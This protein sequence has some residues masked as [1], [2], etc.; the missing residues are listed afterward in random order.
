M[1]VFLQHKTNL[2]MACVSCLLGMV[3]VSAR[4]ILFL[5]KGEVMPRRFTITEKWSDSWFRRLSVEGKVLFSYL[6]DVCDVAGFWEIDLELATFNTGISK[7][8]IPAVFKQLSK[9][10]IEND[11]FIFLQNFLHHQGNFPLKVNNNAHKGILKAFLAHG[12]FGETMLAEVGGCKGLNEID[13]GVVRTPSKGKGKSK[14]K[15]SVLEGGVG[16]TADTSIPPE[17]NL[18]MYIPDYYTAAKSTNEIDKNICRLWNTYKDEGVCPYSKVKFQT[19]YRNASICFQ[20]GYTHEEL[21]KKLVDWRKNSGSADAGPW[22]IW[23]AELAAAKK[24]E[25]G[26]YLYSKSG[27]TIYYADIRLDIS[28]QFENGKTKEEIRQYLDDKYFMESYD[29]DPLLE[30]A[31]QKVKP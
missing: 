7:S 6:C 22:Q 26:E 20:N 16:E 23:Q 27:K 9:A 1:S 18:E 29:R 11:R 21:E 12:D 17:K 14:G 25:E 8:K 10:Y 28:Q 13:E 5:F 31:T 4:V 3:S 30:E 24:K 19:L 2:G 15:G